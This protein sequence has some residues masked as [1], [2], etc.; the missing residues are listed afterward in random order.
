MR[1]FA[2][3]GFAFFASSESGNSRC[4]ETSASFD[5]S[6]S[7]S[8]VYIVARRTYAIRAYCPFGNCFT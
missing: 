7:L 2:S 6:T 4:S 8:A 5:Y 1:A 3:R